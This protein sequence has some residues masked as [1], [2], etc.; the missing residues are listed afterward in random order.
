MPDSRAKTQ[1]VPA[2][3]PRCHQRSF[4]QRAV[5][6][7]DRG[8]F[9][10]KDCENADRLIRVEGIRRHVNGLRRARIECTGGDQ[11]RELTMGEPAPTPNVQIAFRIPGNWAGAAEFVARLP[12]GVQLK[13]ES[14][15]LE[16]GTELGFFPMDSDD[17][18]ADI[19]ASSC[20]RPATRNELAI[21]R[22]YTVNIGLSGPGGSM[23]AARTMMKAAAMILRAGGAGVFID[24]SG[25]SHG[26][27]DWLEM[28]ED[29]GPDAVSFAYLS[30]IQG[31]KDV[32]TMGFHTMGKPD[33]SMR[34][35]DVDEDENSII[36]MIS[37]M[38][39]SDI[40]IDDGHLIAGLDGPRYRAVA[41]P[42]D[43]VPPD[44]PMHNPFGRLKL[45]S[46]RDL[47]TGN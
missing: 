40:A 38:A 13:E 26:A 31:D 35:S 45:I 19:F 7:T 4:T 6:I 30:V 41:G 46:L 29:G 23:D 20:R 12:K 3:Q 9:C 34:R 22:N 1:D 32:W 27:N 16:D 43:R 2:S 36:E 11:S 28:T 8:H 37:Y 14:I 15:I 39:S 44:S 42:C 47:S 24:N 17:R 21:I 33:F 18:F 5:L 10:A 25:L